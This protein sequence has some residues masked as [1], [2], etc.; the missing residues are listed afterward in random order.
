MQFH[1]EALLAVPT[2]PSPPWPLGPGR[3]CL[4]LRGPVDCDAGVARQF[5]QS[6]ARSRSALVFPRTETRHGPKAH[7]RAFA[8]RPHP[9]GTPRTRDFSPSNSGRRTTADTGVPKLTR[10][11]SKGAKRRELRRPARPIS[12]LAREEFEPFKGLTTRSEEGSPFDSRLT[13]S[14]YPRPPPLELRLCTT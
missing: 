10:K 6:T 14:S 11:R 1:F 7:R 3:P 4:A 12:S 9:T 5:T 8:P 2:T 13:P